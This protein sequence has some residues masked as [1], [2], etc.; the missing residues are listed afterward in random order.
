MSKTA[1][2][3]MQL[4]MFLFNVLHENVSPGCGVATNVTG[5]GLVVFLPVMPQTDLVSRHKV[6]E[7][8]GVADPVVDLM[9]R[10][11]VVR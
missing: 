11:D 8:T 3:H 6:T 10:L 1:V 9:D 7:L 4:S 5:E 2:I